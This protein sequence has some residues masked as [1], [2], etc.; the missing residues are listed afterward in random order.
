MKRGRLL[1][2]GASCTTDRVPVLGL[3]RRYASGPPEPLLGLST[4]PSVEGRALGRASSGADA[5]QSTALPGA[6]IGAI[7]ATID[8]DESYPRPG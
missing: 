3:L 8:S 7:P 1:R 6:A 5:C 4:N 2:P